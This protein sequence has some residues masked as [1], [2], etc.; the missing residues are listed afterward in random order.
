MKC[1]KPVVHRETHRIPEIKFEDPQLSSFGPL[2]MPLKTI[3]DSVDRDR[4]APR[5]L[6]VARVLL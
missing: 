4:C 6:T 3:A 2:R 5:F 1:S